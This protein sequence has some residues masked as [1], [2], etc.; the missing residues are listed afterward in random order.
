MQQAIPRWTDAAELQRLMTLVPTEWRSQVAMDPDFSHTLGCN[1]D[2]DWAQWAALN[3]HQRNL[4]FWY[5]LSRRHRPST[6]SPEKLVLGIGLAVALVELIAQNVL[7]FSTALVVAGLA[8]YQLY[9]QTQG[10]QRFRMAAAADLGAIQLALQFGYTWTD[11]YNSLHSALSALA[12]RAPRKLDRNTYAVRLRALEIHRSQ[13]HSSPKR[14]Q[15]LC[16]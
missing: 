3:T 1:L 10:E 15:S 16:H 7:G 12:R 13:P 9:Q 6:R 8:G 5:E 4:L 14:V 2:L 11:A